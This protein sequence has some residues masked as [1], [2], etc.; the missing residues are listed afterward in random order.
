MT[1]IVECYIKVHAL[2]CATE[3]EAI[4]Q[5]TENFSISIVS[6][7]QIIQHCLY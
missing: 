2:I 6:G 1:T 5:L 7:P 3:K 4:L